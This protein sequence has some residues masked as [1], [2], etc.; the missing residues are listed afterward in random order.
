M[1]IQPIDYQQ[2]ELDRLLEQSTEVSAISSVEDHINFLFGLLKINTRYYFFV[3]HCHLGDDIVSEGALTF[4][5]VYKELI[6]RT[7]TIER[8]P[9]VNS[10]IFYNLVHFHLP[11][12]DVRSMVNSSTPKQNIK[13]LITR[14]LACIEGL[15]QAWEGKDPSNKMAIQ[16]LK[17][18]KENDNAIITYLSSL[19]NP[20]RSIS[21]AQYDSLLD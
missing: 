10:T 1:S 2:Q 18:E 15:S 3:H 7:F 5:E 11:L 19:L 13:C 17:N 12:E 14:V 20:L 6:N 8:R 16:L 21:D 9:Y 4:P